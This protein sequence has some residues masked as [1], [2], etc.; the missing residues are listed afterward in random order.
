MHEHG[1]VIQPP[2][3]PQIYGVGVDPHHTSVS[4]HKHEVVSLQRSRTIG[5]CEILQLIFPCIMKQTSTTGIIKLAAVCSGGAWTF[6]LMIFDLPLNTNRWVDCEWLNE[7]FRDPVSGFGEGGSFTVW[8]CVLHCSRP[9]FVSWRHAQRSLTFESLF[10]LYPKRTSVDYCAMVRCNITLHWCCNRSWATD[11]A[12]SCVFL[13]R[14]HHVLFI[15]VVPT[16]NHLS[17]S[18]KFQKAEVSLPFPWEVFCF[19]DLQTQVYMH[20][21]FCC[22]WI[23]VTG[24]GSHL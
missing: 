23:P 12:R 14:V 11:L 19:T 13:F 22:D 20:A 3:L 21:Y 18:F 1:S 2:A 8:V 15:T 5:K 10:N 16:K 17:R 24:L 9:V 7:I 6:N 4:I